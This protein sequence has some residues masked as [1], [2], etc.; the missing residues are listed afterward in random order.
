MKGGV[1]RA[2]GEEGWE[3]GGGCRRHED[4]R[5]LGTLVESLDRIVSLELQ[6]TASE[7][8]GPI[9]RT[10]I[11]DELRVVIEP[12][13][14][15][16]EVAIDWQIAESLPPVLADQHTL[17]QVFLNLIQNSVR[18]LASAERKAVTIAATFE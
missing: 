18:A 6:Q 14:R 9:D 13:L 17:L 8:A 5:A 7:Q 2:A 1:L 16:S 12:L 3:G 15:E 10:T 11:L 4:Y